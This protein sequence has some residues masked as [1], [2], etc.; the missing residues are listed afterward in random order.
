MPGASTIR[1]IRSDRDHARALRKIEEL[2]GARRGTPEAERLEVLATLVDAYESKLHA[3]EPPGPIEAIRF[4]MEQEGLTR[5]DLEELIGSRARVS[6]VLNGRR[7]LTLA[8]I[9][10]IRERLGISADV[11]VGN[12]TGE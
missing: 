9:R 1:P 7:P 4:R 5:A 2:W 11:L 3:I 12:E 8:M 10:R 6:E